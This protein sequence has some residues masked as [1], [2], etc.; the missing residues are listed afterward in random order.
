M[1]QL[2]K[3]FA[4]LGDTTRMAIVE[5]LL[6]QGEL[7]VGE[8]L[9]VADVSPPA[10]S[11]HLKVLRNAGVISQKIDQQRRI[12]AVRKDAVEQINAWTMSRKEFWGQSLE[13][14]MTAL[15]IEE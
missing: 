14:L 3:S 8:L 7:S 13:R 1:N 6:A 9:D 4:A 10:I 12:Y 15:K 5:R 2:V 11:R